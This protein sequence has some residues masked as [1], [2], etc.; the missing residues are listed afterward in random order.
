MLRTLRAEALI[1][2]MFS[3]EK[4]IKMMMR[5]LQKNSQNVWLSMFQKTNEAKKNQDCDENKT[6]ISR[7]KNKRKFNCDDFFVRF[8]FKKYC[9]LNRKEHETKNE[10]IVERTSFQQIRNVLSRT[11]K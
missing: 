8:N 1:R 6:Y 3:S 10:Q 2:E 9:D 7:N 4:N 11:K 5:V